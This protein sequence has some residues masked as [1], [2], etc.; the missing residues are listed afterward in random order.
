[1][2]LARPT[3]N[4]SDLH[5]TLLRIERLLC[6]IVPAEKIEAMEREKWERDIQRIGL[7]PSDFDA[8]A[9]VKPQ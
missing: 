9:E 4:L 3:D 7:K 2:I 6:L 1:M 5:A 8:V